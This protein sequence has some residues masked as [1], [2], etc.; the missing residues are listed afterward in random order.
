MNPTHL[1]ISRRTLLSGAASVAGGL[2]LPKRALAESVPVLNFPTPWRD[3]SQYIAYVPAACKTGPFYTYSCEFDAS[4]SILKTFGIDT[5]MAEQL[6][7]LPIDYRLEPYYVWDNNGAYIYGGDITSAFSGDYT[8]NFLCRTT[9]PVMRQVFQHYG[10]YTK[11]IK[12]QQRIKNHLNRGRLIWIKITVDFKDWTPATWITPE[13]EQIQVVLSNDHAMVVIGYN[14]DVVVIRDCLGPTDTN[15]QRPY[16]F[17][18]PWDRFMACWGAQGNDG[19]SV[20][21]PNS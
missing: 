8:S 11:V 18:V 10:M 16:E 21:L 3:P 20:G 17:E 9:G 5:T 15:W 13:G 6:Q 2:F 4:W 1:S 7:L 19:L 14:D 12:S